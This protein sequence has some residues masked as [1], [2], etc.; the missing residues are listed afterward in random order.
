MYGFI[1]GK[2]EKCGDNL[3]TVETGGGVGYEINVTDNTLKSIKEGENKIY[4]RLIVREDDMRLF[5]FYTLSER[6]M[7]DRL[8]GVS[9]LGPKTALAAL[10]GLSPEG[11][12]AAIVKNDSSGLSKIKGIGKK[13]AERIILELK[14]K[15]GK[16]F[17]NIDAGEVTVV[18]NVSN[19]D[20]VM[21]LMTLG[22]SKAEATAAV[23][24]VEKGLS[25][26]DTVYNAL[27]KL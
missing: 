13:T 14:D 5:G 3:I 11:I 21:A 10:S 8:I 17:S 15:V 18:D 20:A 27:K 1:K 9:G 22:Y 19:D 24:L 26:E 4:T 2:T 6:T 7:F 12:A 23:A 25:L 16:D